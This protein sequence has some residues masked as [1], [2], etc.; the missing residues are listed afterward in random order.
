[1]RYGL[2]SIIFFCIPCF[3]GEITSAHINQIYTSNKGYSVLEVTYYTGDY[4]TVTDE[5]SK[6]EQI[7][8]KRDAVLGNEKY[9]LEHDFNM[10]D[11]GKFIEK[12]LKEKSILIKKETLNDH[13]A[14]IKTN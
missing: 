9:L 5:K 3:A 8:Y 4:T 10:K 2:L 14:K 12:K 11:L 13:N 1:M 7:V 6:K